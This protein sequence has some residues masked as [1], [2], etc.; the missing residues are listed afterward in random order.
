V[1]NV[2]DFGAVG[3][4]TTDDI[5]AINAAIT[6]S[7]R[8]EIY[9]PKGTYAISSPFTPT[10]DQ[11][12]V[13]DGRTSSVIKKIA[14]NGGSDCTSV[15]AL[16]AG[17]R[18]KDI[19]FRCNFT[20]TSGNT[21]NL[22]ATA[23]IHSTLIENVEILNCYNG[24]TLNA[25]YDGINTITLDKIS[26]HTVGNIGIYMR[27]ETADWNVGVVHM[28]N[29]I[30][31][32]GNETATACVLEGEVGTLKFSNCFFGAGQYCLHIRGNATGRIPRFSKFVN[33]ECD[34]SVSSAIR[35]DA[36]LDMEFT[37]TWASCRPGNGVYIGDGA[38]TISFVNCDV[39]YNGR[40]GMV[41]NPGCR[42]VIVNGCN[43]FLNN[44]QNLPQ[45]NFVSGIFVHP[46]A[47][48]FTITNN[49]ITAPGGG[50]TTNQYYGICVYTGNSDYYI[51][52]N[53]NLH[54]NTVQG[55]LDMGTGLNKVISGN[56]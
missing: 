38:D 5:V 54:G 18:I 14:T 10:A 56:L 26:I 40:S 29:T 47:S 7:P 36:A 22:T 2:K 8:D 3:D 16:V 20:P 12:I 1:A 19:G 30:V 41:L 15:N 42:R 52:S 55:L 32:C 53:N 39:Y 44:Q 46:G 17:L 31:N 37:N 21:I 11:T 13:G 28:D 51:I 43:I 50:A 33:V 9:F 48:H 27:G 25:L 4:G 34:S 6:A 35:I 49:I 45:S 24:I 23:I